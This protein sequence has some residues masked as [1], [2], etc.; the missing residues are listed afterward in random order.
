M[1]FGAP[2][3]TGYAGGFDPTFAI[4]SAGAEVNYNAVP[5]YGRGNTEMTLARLFASAGFRGVRRAM[6]VLNGAAP[7]SAAT[8]TFSR[9][10]A[11]VPFNPQ[12]AGG[13]RTLETVTANSGNTTA[14][15]RDYINNVI[16]DARFGSNP[17]NYPVD[18]SGSGGGGKVNF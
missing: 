16:L 9:V 17:A 11:Q 18:L 5:R 15:Q 3:V 12:T 8:E 6:R 10:A 14:A 4:A 13:L 1:A 2:T 7:G